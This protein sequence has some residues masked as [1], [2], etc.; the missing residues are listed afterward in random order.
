M[1]Q[2][3]PITVIL[4]LS[5]HRTMKLLA[6]KHGIKIAEAYLRAVAAYIAKEKAA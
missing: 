4:P 3:K 1:S 6:A 5:L 2:T